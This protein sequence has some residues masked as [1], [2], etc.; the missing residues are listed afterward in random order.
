MNIVITELE[1]E[2]VKYA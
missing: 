1:V 2:W